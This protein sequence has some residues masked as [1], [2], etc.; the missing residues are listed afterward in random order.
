MCTLALHFLEHRIKSKCYFCG[1]TGC[2]KAKIVLGACCIK[3]DAVGQLQH[4][5][6]KDDMVDVY[7][8]LIVIILPLMHEILLVNE[9][10][11]RQVACP[12]PSELYL[13]P[14]HT[15]QVSNTAQRI[16]LSMCIPP[17]SV[18]C[19]LCYRMRCC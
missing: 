19:T 16:F 15:K 18:F 10:H 12:L 1:C 4:T 17:D 13:H 3:T 5:A 7:I 11:H 14:G 9:L 8:W 2:S 6:G